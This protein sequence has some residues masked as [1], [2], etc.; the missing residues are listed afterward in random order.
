MKTTVLHRAHD[1]ATIEDVISRKECEE[2]IALAEKIGFDVA[3]ITTSR[4]FVMAPEIRDNTRVMLDD[5]DRAA[6]L[7]KRLANANVVP[8]ERAG[9]WRAVGLNERFRF[10]RYESGQR[11]R[12]HRDGAFIRSPKERSHL[13]LLLYLNEGCAGGETQIDLGGE[14]VGHQR[15]VD[16]SIE[17]KV[18]R[19]LLFEHA[20]R[21]QGAPVTEGRKYVL[22]TDVMYMHGS[23]L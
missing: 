6:D 7:W 8:I 20:V 17:P 2:L 4:G 19:A 3:P 14:L 15:N 1:I 22:R 23:A 21:H 18:G 16:L 11:F 13:T 9:V 5:P 12:W 10:Y